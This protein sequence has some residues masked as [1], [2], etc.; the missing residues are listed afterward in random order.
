MKGPMEPMEPEPIQDSLK[1]SKHDILLR[2]LMEQE[3]FVS[4]DRVPYITFQD[5]PVHKTLPIQSTDMKYYLENRLFQEYQSQASAKTWGETMD[6]L[7]ARAKCR[8][9]TIPVHKRVAEI[10]GKY[11]LDLCDD[12]F[13]TV[14]TSS[15]GWSVSNR[16][17]IKFRRGDGSLPLPIPVSSNNGINLL[18]PLVNIPNEDM[19]RLAWGCLVSY[20][21]PGPHPILFIVSSQDSGKSTT[22]RHLRSIVDPCTA[23]ACGS[24]TDEKSIMMAAKN[25]HIL[26]LDNISSI[27]QWMSDTL[28]RINSGCGYRAKKM[29]SDTDEIMF[30]CQS[31]IIVNSIQHNMIKSADLGDRSIILEVPKINP[32]SRLSEA[33]MR[34]LFKLNHPEI[35]GHLLDCLSWY[36]ATRYAFDRPASIFRMVDFYRIMH[37]LESH[38]GWPS[39]SFATAYRNN[40]QSV[41]DSVTDHT[42]VSR[43]IIN[44]MNRHESWEGTPQEL[45]REINATAPETER[46]M[47]EWPNTPQAVSYALRAISSNL[48]E[49]IIYT[50]FWRETDRNRRR[51]I[52]LSHT[53]LDA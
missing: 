26:A 42:V 33:E 40:R 53:P 8:G 32:S 20:L 3:L 22:C 44:L 15:T 25:S 13:N 30:H 24:P 39:M 1:E 19:Y 5:G 47:K 28:C 27:P 43:H 50:Q 34:G 52:T 9:V 29:Y 38:L 23:S 45:L 4:P 10:D 7:V 36:Q 46:K 18:R 41:M 37:V 14:E 16:G 48:E 21:A 12:G 35:L 17:D 6:C 31:A 11:Y 51:M 49:Y 2:N